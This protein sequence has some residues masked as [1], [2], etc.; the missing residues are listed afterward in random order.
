MPADRAT[1]ARLVEPAGIVTVDPSTYLLAAGT[2]LLV[3][4]LTLGV[5]WWTRRRTPDATPVATPP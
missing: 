2:V 5:S 4:A 3:S 1:V